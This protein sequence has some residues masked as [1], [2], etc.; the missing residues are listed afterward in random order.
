LIQPHFVSLRDFC[1]SI[2][3]YHVFSGM[4][5]NGVAQTSKIRTVDYAIAYPS[6]RLQFHGTR[7]ESWTSNNG[8]AR[9]RKACDLGNY[10]A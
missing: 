2:G 1:R 8:F 4:I 9:A 10:F 5:T 7:L 3:L 6:A